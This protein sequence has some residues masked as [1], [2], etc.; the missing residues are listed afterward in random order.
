MKP[1]SFRLNVNTINRLAHNFDYKPPGQ[2][3]RWA[4]ERFGEQLFI[5]TSLQIN[6][7]AI[8]DMAYNLK[9]NIQLIT[10]DTGRL[11]N[12]TI[13]Y[14]EKI[15]K[16]YPQA[17]WKV[18][19]P[20]QQEVEQMV[21]EKGR[22]L[23]YE[24]VANRLLCCNIRKIRPL[25]IA[26]TEAKAKAWISGLRRDQGPTRS[27]VKKIEI[28]YSYNGII[29]LNPLADWSE[30][31][32]W[33]YLRRYKVPTHPLYKNNY[34]SIGCEPCTRPIQEYD[35]KRNGRWWWEHN[36]PKECGINCPLNLEKFK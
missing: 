19:T 1:N 8:L 20:D 6:T 11:P 7:M 25:A 35:E 30:Q 26:L 36:A 24:T 34:A 27:H 18:V 29:K 31:Q 14:L 9:P 32:V 2:I 10:I 28:D 15:R 17:R 33:S 23:F 4:I 13:E 12:T 3:I 22:D 21:K 16:K 5:V